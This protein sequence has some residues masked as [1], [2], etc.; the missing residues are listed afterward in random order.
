[1][2][3]L[4]EYMSPTLSDNIYLEEE[5][6]L[7]LDFNLKGSPEYIIGCSGQK[8]LL[9]TYDDLFYGKYHK[10]LDNFNTESN[11]LVFIDQDLTIKDFSG[12]NKLPTP[13]NY[14][15]LSDLINSTKEATQNP[16]RY[17]YRPKNFPEA[18]ISFLIDTGNLGNRDQMDIEGLGQQGRTMVTADNP[19]GDKAEQET[20]VADDDD[21]STVVGSV[22]G[23]GTTDGKVEMP[24]EKKI[25]EE[26][27]Y[28][29]RNGFFQFSSFENKVSRS[30]YGILLSDIEQNT[31]TELF[32]IK[33]DGG[34]YA[35][36]MPKRLKVG[37][38]TQD[39]LAFLP[40]DS[41]MYP[42]TYP[43]LMK[44][45]A[46]NYGAM[47]DGRSLKLILGFL[48]VKEII[49]INGNIMEDLN[50]KSKFPHKNMFS[51][52]DKKN[53]EKKYTKSLDTREIRAEV[54]GEKLES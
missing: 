24:V 20:A 42:D 16:P 34:F 26:I 39:W 45:S 13:Q 15:D 1:M 49:L 52:H 9:T 29:N 25:E 50:L 8:I 54:N 48:D 4:T 7:K 40:P 5:Q 32:S 43:I 33:A 36:A 17:V 3:S 12:I 22:I 30:D 35:S 23:G 53:L 18:N 41:S 31:I 21:R 2:K 47:A 14:S 44:T 11:Y 51:F 19:T 46:F 38:K 10:V 37:K 6:E 28:N 27:L